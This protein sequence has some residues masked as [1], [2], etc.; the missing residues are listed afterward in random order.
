MKKFM[1]KYFMVNCKEATY[2]MA[3]K[4]EGR[5]SI[6]ERLKLSMHTSMCSLCKKFE[7]QAI[8][9][10][11]ESKHVHA[12]QQLPDFTKEKIEQLIKEYGS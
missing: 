7:R 5:L 8:K 2:L 11:A 3:K 4:E 12:E 9:I 1:M 6:Q 10:G